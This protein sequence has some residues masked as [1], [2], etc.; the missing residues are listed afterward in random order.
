MRWDRAITL[1]VQRP[2]GRLTGT[3]RRGRLPI[4]MYH[5]ISDAPEP[6]VSGYY[7]TNT[8]PGVFRDHVGFLAEHGYRS[9]S[10]PGLLE[11]LRAGTPFPERSVLLTFD[12]GLC[13]F[14]T[15]AFPVLQQ[16]GFT[17]AVFLATAFIGNRRRAFAPGSLAPALR[18]RTSAAGGECL[19]WNEVREMRK[20]GIDFGS[21]TVTH[22]KL[23]E[24]DWPRIRS[25][26][27]DSKAEME[28]Q[29][30]EP[31]TAFC[32]PYA[33]PCGAKTFV[34][35]FRDLLVDAGY[36]CCATTVLG[37]V[38]AGDDPFSLKRLP[39]NSL[40]DLALFQAKL[41]GNYDWLAGP[42]ALFKKLT[43]RNRIKDGVACSDCQG[44]E[45]SN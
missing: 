9:L 2:L 27:S 12:D 7:R 13:N 40:D 8:A 38:C 44:R 23:V 39:A 41:D 45:L 15:E 37:R 25:E 14:Y 33:F 6:R 16:H 18:G 34:A 31:V 29:L 21:H 35:A 22:P 24:L 10:L 3:A 20:A 4:L 43:S 30:G 32:Y 28:Q 26:L 17:A 19:S 42:Q 11:L 1:H 5:S 36:A